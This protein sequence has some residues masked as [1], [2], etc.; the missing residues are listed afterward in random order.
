M[1]DPIKTA[2]AALGSAFAAGVAWM[3]LKGRVERVTHD[4][5]KMGRERVKKL[6]DAVVALTAL[7][8]HERE[9]SRIEREEALRREARF[10]EWLAGRLGRI[11]ERLDIPPVGESS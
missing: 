6:E 3:T 5:N 9:Q 11:E 1:L 10:R 4:L 2:F 7:L 8:D